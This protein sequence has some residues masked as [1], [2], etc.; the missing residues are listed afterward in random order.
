MQKVEYKQVCVWSDDEMVL[1]EKKMFCILNIYGYFILLYNFFV[2]MIIVLFG[3][4]IGSMMVEYKVGF[5]D[6]DIVVNIFDFFELNLKVGYDFN[7]YK[8]II[9]QVNVGVY[10]IFNVY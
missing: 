3:I 5:I 2:L 7:L 4:Y 9:M 6:K 8:G 10:N 1:M